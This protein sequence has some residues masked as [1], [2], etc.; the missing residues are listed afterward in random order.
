[1]E[2][3]GRHRCPEGRSR[4]EGE[5]AGT[6]GGWRGGGLAGGGGAARTWEVGSLWPRWE[7][8]EEGTAGGATVPERE[9][10]GPWGGEGVR[11]GEMAGGLSL[12]GLRAMGLGAQGEWRGGGA[13]GAG[14]G[15]CF[16]I[17]G[18]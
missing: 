12:K 9:G 1:M 17:M 11:G 5:D 13:P 7:R 14:G 6:D 3:V 4:E 18:K 16:C 10:E 15:G 8:P 2:G